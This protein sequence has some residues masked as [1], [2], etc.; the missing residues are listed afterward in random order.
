MSGKVGEGYK[1]EQKEIPTYQYIRNSGNTIGEYIEGTITVIYY[2]DRIPAGGLIVKYVDEDGNEIEAR[3]GKEGYVGEEYITIQKESEGYEFVKITGEEPEGHL[4]E[5]VIEVIYHYKKLPTKVIVKYLEKGTEKT[6]ADEDTIDGRVSDPYETARKVIEGYRK[7]DPE[8]TNSRG[9]MTKDTI[10]VIYYYERI[11]SGTITVKYVDIETKEEI[12]YIDENGEEKT[13]REELRG[14][15]GERYTTHEKDIPG[16]EYVK[17]LVPAN[18]EGYFTEDNDIVIYY[19]RKLPFNMAVEKRIKAI[20]VNG[21]EVNLKGEDKVAKQEVVASRIATT[22][23][24]VI[25]EIVVTNTEKVAGTA[26][27]VEAAPAFYRIDS[28]DTNTWERHEEKLIATIELEPGESKVYEIGTKWDQTANSFGQSVNVVRITG[29]D[30]SQGYPETTLED[31]QDF[32]TVVMSIKTGKAMRIGLTMLGFF[33][34]SG[35]LI[36]LYQYQVYTKERGLAIRHV[37]L[38]GENVVI[39]KKKQK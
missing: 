39:R 2:Y 3:E 36:L 7:A 23:V 8:P 30:N 14:Y 5:G 25:Y 11:P 26:T 1:T 29:T 34:C 35:L 17:E 24:R 22:E 20:T 38:E 9:T 28:Y 4:I 13:Y 31:N 37:V 18:K 6:L 33:S 10:Y 15:V 16:Y 12:P 27:V 19:Y 21:K 32:T